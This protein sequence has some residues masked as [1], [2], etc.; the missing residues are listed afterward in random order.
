M[1]TAAYLLA[2]AA[3]C[4]RLAANIAGDPL[5]DVL[6]KLAQEFE[7][8]AA[9]CIAREKAG[10]ASAVGEDARVVERY[11]VCFRNRHTL[12]IGRDDFF[13]PNDAHAIV[14]A[15][16]LADACS[17]LC[18]GFELWQ[19]EREIDHSKERKLRG[20][21][22]IALKVQGIVLERELVLRESESVIAS[23]ARL[24]EETDR[25]LQRLRG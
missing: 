7:A 9:T 1:E 6:I 15:R 8:N 21:D 22:E 18:T 11:H 17:D 3:Q 19:S 14:V 10:R 12:A 24:L 20:A 25:L 5:H 23:S 13:A 4:R 16:T 2:K